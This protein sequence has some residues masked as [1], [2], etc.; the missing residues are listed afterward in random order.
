MEEVEEVGMGRSLQS[1]IYR[2]MMELISSVIFKY[3]HNLVS[4]KSLE[5]LEPMGTAGFLEA[6][7]AVAS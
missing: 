4:L 5:S 2:F 7:E 1:I 6:P 3:E